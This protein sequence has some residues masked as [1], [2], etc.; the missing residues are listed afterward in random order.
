MVVL[1]KPIGNLMETKVTLNTVGMAWDIS[2]ERYTGL[3]D[4]RF[5]DLRFTKPN[6]VIWFELEEDREFDRL[7]R[8]FEE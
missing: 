6:K 1:G 7:I 3:V 5:M 2:Q 4:E 8:N